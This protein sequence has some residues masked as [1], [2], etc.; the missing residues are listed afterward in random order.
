MTGPPVV[1]HHSKSGMSISE[2]VE[3]NF[4][5]GLA[6]VH[7]CGSPEDRKQVYRQVIK[8]MYVLGH[9]VAV[10]EWI[11]GNIPEEVVSRWRSERSCESKKVF[12]SPFPRLW[13]TGRIEDVAEQVYQEKTLLRSPEWSR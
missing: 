9:L 13:I 12:E 3:L 7:P 1:I 5:S 6:A 4:D 10:A 8:D 2:I 11:F